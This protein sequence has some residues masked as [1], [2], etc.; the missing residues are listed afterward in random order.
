MSMSRKAVSLRGC[1]GLSSLVVLAILPL[2]LVSSGADAQNLGSHL[3]IN[4]FGTWAYGNTDG[5]SYLYG[6]PDGEYERMSAA[7]TFIGRPY[8]G[9]TIFVQPNFEYTQNDVEV[10]LGFAFV[11]WEINESFH[12]RAG[13][14]RHP[15]GIYTEIFDVGTL[16]PFLNLPQGIYAPRT[17]A[18]AYNGLGINGKRFL[19]A[20]ASSTTSMADRSIFSRWLPEDM[21]ARRS[22]TRLSTPSVA[23]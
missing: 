3:T 9:V 2:L 7:L 16:R 12:L 22:K 20:R 13:R 19:G 15:F 14:V 11:D 8:E 1:Q 17:V 21:A 6:G 18:R 23:G 5:N 4:G 10:E